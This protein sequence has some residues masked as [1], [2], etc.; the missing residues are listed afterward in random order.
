MINENVKFRQV[1]RDE[2]KVNEY[3][4]AARLG[5]CSSCMGDRLFENI[6]YLT[7][8]ISPKYSAVKLPIEYLSDLDHIRSSATM[9]DGRSAIG[10]LICSS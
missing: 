5:V 1:T 2:F 8:I 9:Q 10:R 7:E 4:L 6:P 3:E